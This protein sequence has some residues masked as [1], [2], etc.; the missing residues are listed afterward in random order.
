MEN[1]VLYATLACPFAH[2][3]MLALALRPCTDIVVNATVPTNNA[4]G[5][6]DRLGLTDGDPLQL[7][8]TETPAPTAEMLRK[9]KAV[10]VSEVT[11]SGETPALQ[12]RCGT[13]VVESE[14]VSE[15]I[16][17]V[18]TAPGPRLVP[19]DDPVLASKVPSPAPTP[20][21]L[22]TMSLP[23]PRTPGCFY[24][25]SSGDRGSWKNVVPNWIEGRCEGE[26]ASVVRS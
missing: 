24:C 14:I 26:S 22:P 20:P 4:L 8:S 13:V 5:Q 18:S 19:V 21:T 25:W 3:A 16:D 2:R 17:N 1:A 9:R 11:E 6:I 15:H 7:Y 10:Y 23:I 12:L